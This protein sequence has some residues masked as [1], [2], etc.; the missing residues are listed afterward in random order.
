MIVVLEGIKGTQLY[1]NVNK[2]LYFKETLQEYNRPI[3][4]IVFIE[5]NVELHVKTS[6]QKIKQLIEDA[7]KPEELFG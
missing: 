7:Q 1:V 3:Y 5:G 2:I 6:A 4:S